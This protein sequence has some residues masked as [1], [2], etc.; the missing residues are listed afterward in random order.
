MP[1]SKYPQEL[2][3]SLEIP[4]VRDNITEVGSDI[5][6]SL[7]SAIFNIERTLGINPQG[8]SGNTLAERLNHV[9]DGNGNILDEAL[10][11]VNVLS[12]PIIDNDVSNVAAIQESKLKLNFPTILLQDEITVLNSQLEDIQNT[13]NEVSVNLSIHL[14]QNVLNSH[15]ATSISVSLSETLESDVATISLESNDL[16]SVIE[17]L[18]NSHIN[19]TGLNVSDLN[20]SHK[21]S[22]IYFD[23]SN[24]SDVVESDSVQGAIEDLAQV[25]SVGFRNALRNITSNGRIRK[26]YVYNAYDGQRKNHILVADSGVVFVRNQGSSVTTFTFNTPATI[27]GEI[28]SFDILSLSGSSTE[29]DNTDYQISSVNINGSGNLESV[30]V[31]GG[32]NGISGSSLLANI[33]KNPYAVYNTGGFCCVA[34][35][36]S[37]KT[38]TPDIQFLNP[39]CATIISQGIIPSKITTD[40]HKINI[41]IDDHSAVTLDTFNSLTSD[42]TIDGIVQKINDQ[43]IDQHLNIMAYKIRSNNCYELGLS[44][45]IPGIDGD[46]VRRTIMVTNGSSNDGLSILGF[47]SQKDIY[48]EGITGNSL[49]LNGLILS[50]FGLIKSFT[51]NTISIENGTRNISLLSSTFSEQG[52]KVG[53][54][55][56]IR[57]MSDST[58][59]GSYRIGSISFGVATLDLSGSFTST[60]GLDSRV[61]IVRNSANI[62][63]LTFEEIVSINGTVIFDIFMDESKDVFYSK[64][65]EVDGAI[66]SSNFYG[67]ISDISNNFILKDESAT[68]SIDTSGYATLTDPTLSSGS[69]VFIGTTGS[70]KIFGS[71][72]LSFLTLDVSAS[73]LPATTQSVTIYGYNEVSANNYLLSRGSFATSLGRVL[74]TSSDPGVPSLIDKRNSGTADNNI[75]GNAFV[76]KYIEGPRNDLRGCGVIRG[77]EVTN[78]TYTDAG[79]GNIYQTFSISAGIILVNG[80]RREFLGL[81][82]V[83]IDTDQTYVVVMNDKGCIQASPYI[84]NPLDPGNYV[85]PYF[86]NNVAYLAEITNNGTTASVYDLRLYINNIDYKIASEIKV[87]NDLRFGHF[88]DL[89]KAVKYAKRFSKMF[90]EMGSPTIFICSG[91]YEIDS[92]ILIDFDLKITGSGPNTNLTKTGSIATGTSLTGDAVD[93][94]TALFMIGGGIDSN[95]ADIVSGVELSNFTYTTSSL[96]TNVGVVIALT[97]PLV[98]SSVVIARRA[99]YKFNNI[100]F[101]GPSSIDGSVADPN[102]IG[103]Y[104]LMIGQQDLSLNPISSITMG[105]VEF[106]GCRLNRMGL[107]NGAIKFT[108]SSSSSIKDI[109]CTNNI[110]TFGSPNLGLTTSVVIEYPTTPATSN[111]IETGNSFRTTS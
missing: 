43:C 15:S 34:R 74:G 44:H 64:R 97:Q 81:E 59:D 105:N 50:E 60:L 33:T 49:S 11:R 69:P 12:G 108:E 100:N 57:G 77:C 111:F 110:V 35:P 56:V 14:N 58:E 101:L 30:E 106:T 84:D 90:P 95:A 1:K 28:S 54:L 19:Y 23:N 68:L 91:T 94:S 26:G 37:N 102:K 48:F 22:Q 4:P 18:Y 98:K 2:D 8:S 87:S 96:L 38:N 5:I 10:N 39:D 32:P 103:E 20:N 67:V 109:V 45:N 76:E 21:S 52:V 78:A 72:G 73:S 65:L 80:I 82:N 89:E 27:L 6:N 53:D 92:T 62:D 47:D 71:D 16:Q 79:G 85:S 42:Q 107:E 61:Y 83:R 7:R 13:L 9:I 75:I 99:T 51:E 93:M 29:L 88:T 104:A 36:R 40:N 25:E 3:T 17:E 24:I 70:F 31:F 41:I 63:E 86:E 55:V 46:N 66:S